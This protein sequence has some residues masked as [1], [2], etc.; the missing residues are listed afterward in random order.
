[1]GGISVPRCDNYS[2]PLPICQSFDCAP[3]AP[4][5]NTSYFPPLH[6]YGTTFGCQQVRIYLD[7]TWQWVE[8][9][10]N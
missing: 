6:P 7:G 1:M 2:D 5:P 3:P 4:V 10:D 8:I 9:C